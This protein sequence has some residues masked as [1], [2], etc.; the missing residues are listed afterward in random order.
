MK[1]KLAEKIA[2]FLGILNFLI[3]FYY[4]IFGEHHGIFLINLPHVID[5]LIFFYNPIILTLI[6]T[7]IFVFDFFKNKF[8]NWYCFFILTLAYLPIAIFVIASFHRP[9][10]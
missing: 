3:F 7:G 1:L 10:H 2:T 8:K 4:L 9:S 6:S 5:E